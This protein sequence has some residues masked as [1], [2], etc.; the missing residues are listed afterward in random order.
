M[1]DYVA[2]LATVIAVFVM[3]RAERKDMA[4]VSDLGRVEARIDARRQMDRSDRRARYQNDG[5]P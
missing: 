3:L 2:A 4:K 1:S 5:S